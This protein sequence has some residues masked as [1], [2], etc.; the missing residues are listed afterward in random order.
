ME[1][2]VSASIVH[3]FVSE[4]IDRVRLVYHQDLVNVVTMQAA[5]SEGDVRESQNTLGI[6]RGQPSPTRPELAMPS[7]IRFSGLR[8]KRSKRIPHASRELAAKSLT[9]VLDSVVNK[10]T[11]SPGH[12][13][14]C[15]ALL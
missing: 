14:F 6:R 7:P 15:S 10:M 8:N 1:G 4:R 3:V 12:A 11:I 2:T 13:F 5:I 9:S